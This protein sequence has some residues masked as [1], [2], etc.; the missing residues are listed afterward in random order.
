[1]TPK[2]VHR[3]LAGASRSGKTVAETMRLLTMAL[4]MNCTIALF[5]PHGSLARPLFLHL[6]LR[7]Q[8][9]RVIY[10]RLSDTDRTPV[11]EWLSASRNPDYFQR[12]SETEERIREFISV[13]LRRRGITDPAKTPII[14]EGLLT[15]LRCYVYQETP[16][17]L[18]WLPDL[19]V[20]GTDAY[21]WMMA[22]CTDQATLHKLRTYA[23][24][25]PSKRRDETGPAERI[26]RNVCT[27]PAFMV[28]SGAASF[29]FDGMLDSNC[30]YIVDGSSRGN[31]SRDA[32][33]IMMGSL[34]LR[35][36]N[37]CR[38]KPRGKIVLVLEEA[39]N[40]ALL[41]LF[42]SQALAECAKWGLEIHI[43]VQ[44]PLSFPTPEI[45]FNVMTNTAWGQEFYR[46]GGPADAKFSAE[47]IATP[48]LD[49]LRVHHIE[50]HIRMTDDG[51]DEIESTSTSTYTD[52]RGKQG[53]TAGTNKSFRPRRREVIDEQKRYTSLTDQVLLIQKELMRL[54]PGW[55]FVR[56]SEVSTTPEYVRCLPAPWSF[57]PG[58]QDLKFEKALAELK[59]T[60]MY[61]SPA[62][63]SPPSMPSQEPPPPRDRDYGME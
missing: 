40:G 49:P 31:L 11:Y 18:Y 16:V 6:L 14:E 30:I 45:G 20:P 61:R 17:P 33:S 37:H 21:F 51:Y 29:D 54:E 53:K 2:I 41:G 12:L 9:R 25:N 59:Q 15:A 28:R 13:L 42:E 52:H 57:L 46:Q 22:H 60:N 43:L 19:Y 32:A 4:A 8:G 38:T 35:I 44:S 50:K 58:L 47:T 10:D 23:L 24:L 55:R 5:D 62:I 1:M 63:L 39:V 7:G 3:L 26:L 27:S 36:I 34:I 48:I 56:S